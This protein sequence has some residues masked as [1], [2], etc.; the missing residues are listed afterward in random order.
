MDVRPPEA[1]LPIDRDM[2]L[3]MTIHKVLVAN[4]KA[5]HVMLKFLVDAQRSTGI[6]G[7]FEAE[8]ELADGESLKLFCKQMRDDMV[9]S[10][11]RG[12]SQMTYSVKLTKYVNDDLLAVNM[13]DYEDLVQ[14]WLKD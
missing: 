5:K 6:D 10:V 1:G 2:V 14:H 7:H 8:Y 3:L 12:K 13:K 11:T 9:F 4:H